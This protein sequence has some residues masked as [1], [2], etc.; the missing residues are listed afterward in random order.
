M[1]YVLLR[2]QSIYTPRGWRRCR[3][4]ESIPFEVFSWDSRKA[5]LEYL[6]ALAAGPD[7]YVTPLHLIVPAKSLTSD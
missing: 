3:R 4:Y 7:A 2:R 5:A 6:E 1:K